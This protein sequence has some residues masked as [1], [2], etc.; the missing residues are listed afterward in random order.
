METN[1]SAPFQPI[2]NVTRLTGF[3]ER[4]VREGVKSGVIPHVRV[5][6]KIF[7]DVPKFLAKMHEQ[8][9]AGEMN[10]QK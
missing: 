7:V 6:V 4:F 2:K 1:Y 3:S 9:G 5:G 8:S 10:E